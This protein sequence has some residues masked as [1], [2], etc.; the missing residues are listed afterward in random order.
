MELDDIDPDSWRKLEAATDE[1]ID[2][3][4]D[5]FDSCCKILGGGRKFSK[6]H[7]H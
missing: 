4:N 3:A 7:L 2:N 6:S 1:Y 5:A